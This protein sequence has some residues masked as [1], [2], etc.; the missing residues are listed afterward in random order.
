MSKAIAKRDPRDITIGSMTL[1]A[2]GIVFDG[3]VS[4]DDWQAA[5]A[6][7][8]RA[9]GGVQWW[10]G[11]W[12]LYGEGRPE[13]GDKY[14]A[15]I[16]AFDKEYQTLA[17][18]KWLAKAFDFSRRREKLSFKHHME[19]AALESPVADELLDQAESGDWSSATLRKQAADRRAADTVESK[20]LPPGKFNVILADP[21]WRYDFAQS[22]SR[23]I[24]NHYPTM[25]VDAIC[26]LEVSKKAADD[27]VLFLWATSPKL[28]EAMKVMEAWGFQYTT[29]MVWAKDKIGMGYYA[30]QQHEL[31]LI[32]IC[33]RPEVPPTETRPPSV[34]HAD[35]EEHSRKPETFYC[36]I[37]KMYP[38]AKRIEFFCRQPRKGWTAWGDEV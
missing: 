7:I 14:E 15:A 28:V 13:W 21:P 17:Q 19:V 18:Y 35:R 4:F 20:P 2:T 37:E 1:S 9:H 3:E 29:C 12:L 31:L 34:I 38:K 26:K 8:E 30:R 27:S 6:L 11:D 10:I 24:E 36:I 25:E 22:D 32:G 16:Q 23:R 33:G 5:G